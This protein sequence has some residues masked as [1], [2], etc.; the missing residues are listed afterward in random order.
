MNQ[1]MKFIEL[2]NRVEFHCEPSCVKL[3]EAI[4]LAEHY[5]NPLTVTNAMLLPMASPATLYRRLESLMEAG[6][7]EHS[8]KGKNRRTKYLVTTARSKTYFKSMSFALSN[9]IF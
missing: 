2:A 5:A 9:S 6:Y 4:A 1:Y 3:L 8:F 7:I